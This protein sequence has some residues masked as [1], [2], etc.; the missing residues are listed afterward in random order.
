MPI[1]ERFV[2]AI[3]A[4]DREGLLGLLAPHIDFRAMTPSRFWE[5]SSA[6]EVVDEVILGHWF[7]P[8][9]R[10]E[11]IE[12]IEHDVVVDRERVGY[13]FRVSNAD[14]EHAVEQQ[15]YLGAQ[16]DVIGWLRI[17]CAGYQP[18]G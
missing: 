18:V 9:D 5:A 1:G 10:I 4:K 13:R 16:D 2:R 17:M 6:A 12:R 15:A 14:G 11:A 8:T 3:A 7:A